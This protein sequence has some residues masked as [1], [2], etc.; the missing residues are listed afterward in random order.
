MSSVSVDVVVVITS[1]L[2]ENFELL[3]LT[4]SSSQQIIKQRNNCEDT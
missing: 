1:T 3:T 2:T 4:K